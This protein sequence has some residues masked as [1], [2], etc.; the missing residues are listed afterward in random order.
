MKKPN[1]RRAHVLKRIKERVGTHIPQSLIEGNLK[2]ES[3]T[4]IKR[5]SCSRSIGYLIIDNTPIKIV[6]GKTC[7]KAIT[8]LSL[9]YDFEFPKDSWFEILHD[10]NNTYRIKIYPDCYMET[11]N[12]RTMTK[13]QIWNDHE[14][15]WKERKHAD[16]IFNHVFDIAWKH[17][18]EYKKYKILS[19]S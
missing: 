7:K 5:V 14:M 17:Y 13:F 11:E 16:D 2:H 3:I 4:F 12:K 6:Y 1:K 9:N 15:K 8:V 19:N 18:E 10:N